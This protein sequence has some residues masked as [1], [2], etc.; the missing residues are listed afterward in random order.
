[1]VLK[2]EPLQEHCITVPAQIYQIDKYLS[3]VLKNMQNADGFLR[4][5]KH[6]MK[7]TLRNITAFEKKMG[8]HRIQG[9]EEWANVAFTNHSP[10]W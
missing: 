10:I 6:F 5:K 4:R 2:P 3:Q 1:M 8:F 7:V 9:N